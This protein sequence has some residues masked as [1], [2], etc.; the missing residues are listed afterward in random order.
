[1]RVRFVYAFV[2]GLACGPRMEPLDV[3][4]GCQALLAPSA[5]CLLPY[6]SDF[7]RRPDVAQPSGFR[8]Q[9]SEA[10]LPRTAGGQPYDVTGETP[11]DGFSTVPTIVATLGVGLSTEGF[12]ALEAGGSPSLSASSSN[13]LLLELPGF[14]PVAHW[15]DVDSRATEGARQAFILQPFAPLKD[16]TRY[17]VLVKGIRSVSGELAPTPEGFRR[18]RDGEAGGDPSLASAVAAFEARLGP[19][20]RAAGV[21]RAALQ[22]AW[23]FTTGTRAWATRD[24]LRVRALTLAW[25]ETNTPAVRVTSPLDEAAD[26]AFRIVRGFFT[27]PRFCSQQA[28][29]G[30]RLGRG[31][32]GQV[33]QAGTVEVPFVAVIPKTV[34]QRVGAS[35]VF[36]YGHGFFGNLDEASGQAARTIASSTKRTLLA[37][38]WWGMHFTDVGPVGDALTGRL[39]QTARF[40]ERVHQGMANWLVLTALA[41]GLGALPAFQRASGE[42]LVTG[43]ADAFIGISQGHILGGTMSAL[44][45]ITT[46]VALNV[47]GAGLTHMMMRAEAFSGLFEL[48]NLSVSDPLEQRKFVAA[49]QRPLDRIDPAT[50]APFVLREPLPGNAPKRVLM[51][52]GLMDGSVPNLGSYLHARALGIPLLT[53]APAAPWGLEARDGP[54]ESGLE[55]HDFQLGDPATFYQASDFPKTKTPVHDALRGLP[56]VLEQLDRFFRDGVIVRT[57][58]GACDPQ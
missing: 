51:Q 13:T 3:P 2:A 37:T 45:P 46:K 43:P 49:L 6:P 36:L 22:L 23:E 21:P 31:A 28:Q 11:I 34:E 12:V 7:F 58:D 19:A 5:E 27:A 26:D 15:V 8:V 14:V 53:P 41:P 9:V 56:A 57:C 25:L 16:D 17:V 18:V 42:A 40:V 4:A 48:L 32:D 52:V 35:G 54:A 1:M 29:P 38:E 33:V 39:S 24:L 50:W 10:A 47:G 30:C 20:A 55:V 44:N